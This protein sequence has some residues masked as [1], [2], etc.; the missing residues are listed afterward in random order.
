LADLYKVKFPV[1]SSNWRY[2][3]YE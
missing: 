1:F 2:S 3:W